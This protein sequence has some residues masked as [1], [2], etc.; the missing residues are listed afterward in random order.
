M[1]SFF[2][3]KQAVSDLETPDSDG[4]S[5]I[6][7]LAVLNHSEAIELMAKNGA[8]VNLAVKGTN[9]TPLVI[10]ASRGCDSTVKVLVRAGARIL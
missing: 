2:N 6:H 10:A 5:L 8:N 3:G 4:V 9:I 7:D 1:S